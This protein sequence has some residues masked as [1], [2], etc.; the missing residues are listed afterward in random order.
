MAKEE[1]RRKPI[2]LFGG[3]SSGPLSVPNLFNECTL[4]GAEL[5]YWREGDKEV[6]FVIRRGRTV[7]AIEV[8][9][10]AEKEALPAMAEF[11]KVFHPK[12]MLLVG[13][14]GVAIE[15]FLTN[16]LAVWIA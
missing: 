10:G 13:T 12:R 3:G 8:K 5:F 11:S 2:D 6:D 16:P 7:T 14:G 15:E 4:A 1:Y 9:S